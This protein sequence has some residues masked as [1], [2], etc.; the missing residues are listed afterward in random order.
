MCG[1]TAPIRKFVPYNLSDFGKLP[2]KERLKVECKRCGLPYDKHHVE[3]ERT[4]L[5][6]SCDDSSPVLPEDNIKDNQRC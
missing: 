3:V 2:N 1:R 5:V 6:R 4:T